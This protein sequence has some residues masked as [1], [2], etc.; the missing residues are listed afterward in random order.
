M[1]Q[2]GAPSPSIQNYP[3]TIRVMHSH[4][5]H[6][7]YKIANGEA[8]SKIPQCGMFGRIACIAWA[9]TAINTLTSRWRAERL[10]TNSATVV[11][12]REV[13]PKCSVAK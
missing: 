2:T 4:L 11:A 3:L 1:T 10:R 13:V 5:T 12:D 7:A 9:V 6:A 8:S